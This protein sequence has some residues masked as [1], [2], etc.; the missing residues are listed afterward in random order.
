M[1]R[2]RFSNNNITNTILLL[3]DCR[4]LACRNAAVLYRQ[5]RTFLGRFEIKIVDFTSDTAFEGKK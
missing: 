5:N 2:D 3:F 4:Q 1:R